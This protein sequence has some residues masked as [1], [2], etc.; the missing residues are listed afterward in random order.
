LPNITEG[1][2]GLLKSD[3]LRQT[4]EMAPL[5]PRGLIEPSLRTTGIVSVHLLTNIGAMIQDGMKKN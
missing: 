2:N 5:N 3:D 1:K 4:P